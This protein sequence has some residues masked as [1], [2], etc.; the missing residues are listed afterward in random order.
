[1][2][3][4]PAGGAASSVCV[5]EGSIRVEFWDLSQSE[6]TY[7]LAMNR[8]TKIEVRVFLENTE[9][10]YLEEQVEMSSPNCWGRGKT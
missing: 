1:M 6:A 4:Q 2:E 10:R 3:R 7:R 5:G 8:R 9:H